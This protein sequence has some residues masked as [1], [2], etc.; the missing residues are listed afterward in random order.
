MRRPEVLRLVVALFLSMLIMGTVN[1]V[2]IRYTEQKFCTLLTLLDDGYNAP[3]Q[4]GQP[5]LTERGKRIADATHLLRV[6]LGCD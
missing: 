3:V 4:P 2:F 6:D 5:P 1:L